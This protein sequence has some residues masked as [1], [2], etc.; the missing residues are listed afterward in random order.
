MKLVNTLA[1]ALL[2][3]LPLAVHAGKQK[4]Q[5]G[6]TATAVDK[7]KKASPVNAVDRLTNGQVKGT[8]IHRSFSNSCINCCSAN[9]EGTNGN[10]S[11]SNATIYKLILR[12]DGTGNIPV[13]IS[14][15]S[16][17]CGGDP[18]VNIFYNIP[19]EYELD[20]EVN[21]LATLIL[22][23]FPYA[24]CNP[25]EKLLFKVRDGQ[26]VGYDQV[27]VKSGFDGASNIWFLGE[28]FKNSDED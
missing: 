10:G 26:V 8:Y 14:T 2:L 5:N 25:V 11:L 24:S 13:L 23:D 19:V 3:A 9:G 4:G 18:K 21:L 7:G 1:L 28:G 17:C 15:T 22:K 6:C 20:D 12:D 27:T 16:H